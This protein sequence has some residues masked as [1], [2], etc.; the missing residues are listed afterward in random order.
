MAR[1]SAAQQS[2]RQLCGLVSGYYVSQTPDTDCQQAVQLFRQLFAQA[3]LDVL[4][5]A[6]HDMSEHIRGSTELQ[7]KFLFHLTGQQLAEVYE[8]ASDPA[9]K[10]SIADL[11]HEAEQLREL[12]LKACQRQDLAEAAMIYGSVYASDWAVP[13]LGGHGGYG[14]DVRGDAL[15]CLPLELLRTL[16]DH[17]WPLDYPDPPSWSGEPKGKHRGIRLWLK[18]EVEDLEADEL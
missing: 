7:E 1:L 18:D 11:L 9:V 15:N 10:E 6:L 8:A 17:D 4:G 12:L 3:K 16:R 14:G 5:A 13:P 2:A